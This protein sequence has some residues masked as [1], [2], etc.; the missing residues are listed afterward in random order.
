LQAGLLR[1]MVNYYINNR[2]N[3][4]YEKDFGTD[5]SYALGA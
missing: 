1:Q 5:G 2:Y 3:I 4:D